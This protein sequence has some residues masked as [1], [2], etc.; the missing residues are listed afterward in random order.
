MKIS[1]YNTQCRIEE[2]LKRKIPDHTY[3]MLLRIFQPLFFSPTGYHVKEKAMGTS[4]CRYPDWTVYNERLVKRGEFYSFSDFIDHWASHLAR[5]STGTG[6]HPFQYPDLF[7]Q[8]M[9][10]QPSLPPGALSPCGRIHKEA[11]PFHSRS[12][13]RRLYHP[14][15]CRIKNLISS[16][17]LP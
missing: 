16:N 13:I 7:M 12:S 11:L 8:W 10:L 9:A 5:M 14:F 1:Y 3:P 6:G 2:Y 4:A 15:L 17:P